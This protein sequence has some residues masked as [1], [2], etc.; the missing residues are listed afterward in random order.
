[1]DGVVLEVRDGVC[2]SIGLHIYECTYV[3]HQLITASSIA[4]KL[5]FYFVLFKML[6]VQYLEVMLKSR[7]NTISPISN[8]V[9]V[10]YHN[11]QASLACIISIPCY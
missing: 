4:A 8:S 3:Q 6:A 7:I 5:T 9:D 2:L 1:M 11:G 10:T